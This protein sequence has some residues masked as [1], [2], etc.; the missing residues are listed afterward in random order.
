MI[1]LDLD[2]LKKIP[3]RVG[4]AY[5]MEKKDAILSVLKGKLINVLITDEAFA[6]YLN[7]AE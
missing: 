1:S 4:V 3:I 7:E 5:G 6:K 2:D